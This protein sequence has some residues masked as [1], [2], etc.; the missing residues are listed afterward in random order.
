MNDPR[1]YRTPNVKFEQMF[2]PVYSSTQLLA[3]GVVRL[4]VLRRI[5]V[6]E[7]LLVDNGN[8]YSTFVS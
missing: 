4:V 8:F 7:E 3:P 6:G 1:L 5:R 2:D